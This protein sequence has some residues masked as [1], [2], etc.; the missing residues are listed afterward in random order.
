MFEDTLLVVMT[1]SPI[2]SHP[3]TQ[4]I[5]IAIDS[6][7]Y[8]LPDVPILILADGVREEQIAMTDSYRQYLV[9]L[10]AQN[11]PNVAIWESD[12]FRH[13]AGMMREVFPSISA[14]LILWIEHDFM[15][16]PRPIP[17]DG[18][19]ATLLE[20][21]ISYIRFLHEGELRKPYHERGEIISHGVPLI[22]T[23]EFTSLPFIAHRDLFEFIIP[24]YET[25][26]IHLECNEVV[27]LFHKDG[28]NEWKWKLA[29]YNPPDKGRYHSLDGRATRGPKLPMEI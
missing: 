22:L 12:T 9:A 29:Q 19:V 20:K 6:I 5:D 16:F 21:K 3:S 4:I 7:R 8:H 10:K 23:M 14:P 28:L 25:G 2:P 1:T 27:G 15:L 11:R 24:R 17:W 26:R 13:Q 18:I